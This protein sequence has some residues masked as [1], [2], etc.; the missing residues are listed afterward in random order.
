MQKNARKLRR[1]VSI[2]RIYLAAS[3]EEFSNRG[4]TW[5]L[6]ANARR[7]NLLSS[8]FRIITI[9]PFETDGSELNFGICEWKCAPGRSQ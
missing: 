1:E 2:N 4:I 9:R 8:P 5:G 3:F 7:S 6:W